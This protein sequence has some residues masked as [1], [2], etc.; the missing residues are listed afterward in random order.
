MSQKL[1]TTKR[2]LHVDKSAFFPPDSSKVSQWIICEKD[3]KD[4]ETQS[5]LL[6]SQDTLPTGLH[7]CKLNE[8]Y[9]YHVHLSWN[10]NRAHKGNY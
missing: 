8:M 6:P 5:D 9:V 10:I 3:S 4:S 1:L 7:T 2:I